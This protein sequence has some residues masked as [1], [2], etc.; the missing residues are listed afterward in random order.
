MVVSGSRPPFFLRAA[1]LGVRCVCVCVVLG[2]ACA[3][4]SKKIQDGA[5][6]GSAEAVF[7]E[8]RALLSPEDAGMTPFEFVASGLAQSLA[9]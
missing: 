1:A 7:E 2:R 5:E 3:R 9:M 8:L 4:L 6:S